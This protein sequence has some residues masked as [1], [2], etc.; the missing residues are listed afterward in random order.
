MS[1][2]ARYSRL[3]HPKDHGCALFNP[4]S[5]DDLPRAMREVGTR[6][7]DVGI[8][9]PNG[10]FD[11]IFNI[12]TVP[13]TIVPASRRVSSR[14]YSAMMLS[15][16]SGSATPRAQIFRIPP[17]IRGGSTST[18]GFVPAGAGA[19]IEVSMNAKETVILVLPDGASRWDLR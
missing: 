4:Q 8:V 19:V 1:D 18:L 10:A 5:F 15:R 6:I 7:G 12:S 3:L 11:P 9:T 2:S 17:A 16:R 13:R 14:S